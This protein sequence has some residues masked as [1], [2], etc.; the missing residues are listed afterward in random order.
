VKYSTKYRIAN[1]MELD[2]DDRLQN[3]GDV[4]ERLEQ[5]QQ[6]Q[7]ARISVVPANPAAQPS[8]RQ[9]TWLQKRRA[10]IQ[11]APINGR[12][13]QRKKRRSTSSDAASVTAAP[14]AQRHMTRSEYVCRLVC[15]A[16]LTAFG[17]AACLFAV[18]LL[19]ELLLALRFPVRSLKHRPVEE[20]EAPGAYEQLLTDA[21]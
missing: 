4:G 16:V 19:E 1:K 5:Q 18:Q 21:L 11:F 3:S 7:Q 12:T 14:T 8:L 17:L 13:R 20:F 9:R 10:L 2:A 15:T 6:Q